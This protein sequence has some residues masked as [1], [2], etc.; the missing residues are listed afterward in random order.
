MEDGFSPMYKYLSNLT[1]KE[2]VRP[3]TNKNIFLIIAE[4]TVFC[5]KEQMLSS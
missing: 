5:I 4:E 3:Y 2:R 1:E